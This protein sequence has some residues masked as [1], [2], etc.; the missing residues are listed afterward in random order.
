MKKFLFLSF[1]VLATISCEDDY[2]WKDTDFENA[3]SLNEWLNEC[4]GYD[5]SQIENLLCEKSW[6][7]I[8]ISIHCTDEWGPITDPGWSF[9]GVDGRG[10]NYALFHN[11][12]TVNFELNYIAA[13]PIIERSY[14]VTAQHWTFDPESR[15][16]TITSTR[17]YLDNGDIDDQSTKF[18]ILAIDHQYMAWGEEWDGEYLIE[19]MKAQ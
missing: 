4:K 8:R 19:L 10:P 9:P 16:L 15:L 5:V 3:A 17:K 14:E 2:E 1:I 11:N 18:Y 13:D 6:K 7:S 12:G